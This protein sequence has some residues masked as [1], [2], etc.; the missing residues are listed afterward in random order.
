MKYVDAN[1]FIFPIIYDATIKESSL[2]KGILLEISEGDLEAATCSLTWDEVAWIVRKTLGIEYAKNEGKK[3][4]EF[5]NLKI[6][7]VNEEIINEAQKIMETYQ[8]KPRDSIHAACAIKNNIGE[9]ITDDPDFD[10]VKE[11]KR[12]SLEKA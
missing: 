8:L 9:I 10:K 5:P 12:I 11:L 6:L 7:T 3:L 1:V 2:S 4:L